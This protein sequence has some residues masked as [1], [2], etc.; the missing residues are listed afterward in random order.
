MEQ[1]V[2]Q[3]DIIAGVTKVFYLS[4][5]RISGLR[6]VPVPESPYLVEKCQCEPGYIGL[7]CEVNNHRVTMYYI[8]VYIYILY[9]IM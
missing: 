8:Y 4:H 2:S 3:Y 9:T 6:I 7:S 1:E 5:Y